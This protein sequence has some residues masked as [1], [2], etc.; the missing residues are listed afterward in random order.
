MLGCTAVGAFLSLVIDAGP[1]F[2]MIAAAI[3]GFVCESA[4]AAPLWTIVDPLL[5]L[6]TSGCRES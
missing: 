4:V 6:A 5:L 3:G 2:N 1:D